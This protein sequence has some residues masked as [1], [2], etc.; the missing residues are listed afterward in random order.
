MEHIS[1]LVSLKE[2]GKQSCRLHDQWSVSAVFS[3]Y[4]NVCDSYSLSYLNLFT[5]LSHWFF[6]HNSFDYFVVFLSSS[7]SY[8]FPQALVFQS[9]K[10]YSEVLC[11]RSIW[12]SRHLLRRWW[13]SLLAW[14]VVC[15]LAKRW[16]TFDFAVS[17]NIHRGTIC[18]FIFTKCTV[19]WWMWLPVGLIRLASSPSDANL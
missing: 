6:F 15:Q 17:C 16:D 19:I 4:S 1:G 11:W 8:F 10:P 3:I 18:P 2:V 14:A 7:N 12:H 5:D 9:W 13:D